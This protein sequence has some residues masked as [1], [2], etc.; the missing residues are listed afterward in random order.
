MNDIY[1]DGTYFKNNPNWHQ[2]ESPWKANQVMNVIK[3]NNLKLSSICDVGCGAGDVLR[4]LSE[5]LPNSISFTGYDISPQAFEISSKKSTSKIKFFL[6]DIL[7]EDKTFDLVTVLDIIEHVDDYY[8]FLRKLKSK[9]RYKLFHIPLD[10]SIQRLLRASLFLQDMKEIG[11]IHFFTKETALAVIQRAG[12]KIIECTYIA[13][14]I[15]LTMGGRKARLLTIPR[16]VLFSLNRDF[17][18]RLFGG[19]SLSVLAE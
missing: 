15:D 9:A 7:E 8:G 17:A 14:R 12:Y 6:G 5:N 18:S 4:L 16:I 3:R 11:H 10:L 1:K 19:W 13:K 2:E